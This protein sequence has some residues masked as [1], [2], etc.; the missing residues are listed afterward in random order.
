MPTTILLAISLNDFIWLVVALF[1]MF[2]ALAGIVLS[3]T[4]L[5]RKLLGRLQL[6]LGPTRTGPMGWQPCDKAVATGTASEKRTPESPPPVTAP[7]TWD[8]AASG[9]ERPP[10][11]KLC[12]AS[13]KWGRTRRISAPPGSP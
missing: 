1:I 10:T 13:A 7:A 2:S 6:R 5:E 4:W 3:L 9:E 8:C 12:V 11:R